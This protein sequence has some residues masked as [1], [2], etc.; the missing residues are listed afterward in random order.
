MHNSLGREP[1]L[2][3]RATERDN[4]DM[5]ETVSW[6]VAHLWRYPVKSMLG[7]Q[8]TEVPVTVRGIENDRLF[9]VRDPDGKLGSGKSTRR[10]RAMEGLF[11]FAARYDHNR[12]VVTMPDGQE[13]QAGERRLEEAVSGWLNRPVT[14]AREADISHFDDSP[15]HLMTTSSLHRLGRMLLPGRLCAGR[16]SG[17]DCSRGFRPIA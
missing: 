8:L 15:L 7:E 16:D 9:A 2:A 3:R 11:R 13:V 4:A 10:F 17:C 1:T 6:T 14:L 12:L 5:G